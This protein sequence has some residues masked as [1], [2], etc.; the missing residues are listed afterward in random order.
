M[1]S[2][3]G[4]PAHI[5]SFL[6]GVRWATIGTLNPDGSPHQAIIWYLIDGDTVVVNSRRGR[7]WPRN[8]ERDGRVSLAIQDWSE[9][10]HW[11][12]LR[13]TARV[14]RSGPEAVR[15]IQL[16]ARRYGGNPDEFNGQDRI[17]FAISVDGAFEYGS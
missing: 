5:R 2:P 17:T 8:L 10:E 13:G 11:V 16:M 3:G 14:L 12:G 15:D 4:I 9:P 7:Q 1:P 6:E